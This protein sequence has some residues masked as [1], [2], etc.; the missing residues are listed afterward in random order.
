MSTTK[1]VKPT[2][3]AAIEAL[4][5]TVIHSCMFL[6]KLAQG[7]EEIVDLARN[8]VTNLNEMQGIRLDATKAER[9]I[10]RVQLEADLAAATAS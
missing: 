7:S 2:F 1:E 6:M 10:T 9:T 4:Y 8:E 3:G 5:L